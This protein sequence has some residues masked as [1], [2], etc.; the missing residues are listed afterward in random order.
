M[1]AVA[2]EDVVKGGYLSV[3]MFVS[4]KIQSDSHEEVFVAPRLA[5]HTYVGRQVLLRVE[6]FPVTQG[7]V[8]IHEG[9]WS[10]QRFLRKKRRST[11]SSR[12]KI[13]R[14]SHIVGQMPHDRPSKGIIK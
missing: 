11:V 7:M 12:N 1:L 2:L 14:M 3:A 6:I 9:G 5:K 10:D 4:A 13:I 8:R